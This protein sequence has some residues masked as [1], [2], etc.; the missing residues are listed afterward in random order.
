[1][2]HSTKRK[3][4]PRARRSPA[5]GS[6]KVTCRRGSLGLSPNLAKTVLDL[7]ETGIRLVVR[8]ALPVKQEIEIGLE[9]SCH[10]GPLRRLANVVWSLPTADGFHCI[11]AQ[12]QRRLTYADLQV[13]AR[14]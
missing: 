12:F 6:C 3:P 10:A 2:N 13:L 5:K 14:V 11:G 8:E 4:R 9:S 1:M 7:S